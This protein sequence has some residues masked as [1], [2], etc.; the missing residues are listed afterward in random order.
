MIA[1]KRQSGAIRGSSGS[2]D[3]DK[4]SGHWW[5]SVYYP[6]AL[7]EERL[8]KDFQR[9]INL[10]QIGDDRVVLFCRS[11]VEKDMLL[12]QAVRIAGDLIADIR[13]LGPELHW[14]D[15][16]WGWAHC[17]LSISGL[18]LNLWN[19]ASLTS[20]AD[21]F[22]GLLE[23]NLFTIQQKNLEKALL[24]VRRRLKSFYPM[25]VSV[26]YEERRLMKLTIAKVLVDERGVD[27][28]NLQE[29]IGEESAKSTPSKV[30]ERMT[31]DATVA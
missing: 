22:Y 13:A 7:I 28:T 8:S 9:N 18:P 26:S 5:S 3:I 2:Y 10:K 25:E 20:I 21:Q 15:L 23:I 6:L 1:E 14:K 19:H 24:N 30:V 27:S 12:L 11:E 17:C 4:T 16:K 31:T 29:L